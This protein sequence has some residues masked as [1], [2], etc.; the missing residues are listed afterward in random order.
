M[1]A[2]SAFEPKVCFLLSLSLLDL[3]VVAVA[4]LFLVHCW[5]LRVGT[6][7]ISIVRVPKGL[8]HRD[9]QVLQKGVCWIKA[10]LNHAA[11]PTF[12]VGS[13]CF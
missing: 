7:D 13:G 8:H 6:E 10:G 9:E 4:A 12:Y 11:L 2:C 3:E 1:L 5:V